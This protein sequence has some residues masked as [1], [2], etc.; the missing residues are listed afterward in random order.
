MA[1]H[2]VK[3]CGQGGMVSWDGMTDGQATGVVEASCLGLAVGEWP[4]Y[5]AIDLQ[6]FK[7]TTPCYRN[8]DLERVVYESQDNFHDLLSVYND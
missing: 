6:L 3:Y 8:G 1:I 4:M 2:E 5:L 7:K